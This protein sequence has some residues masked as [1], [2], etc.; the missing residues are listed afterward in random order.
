MHHCAYSKLKERGGDFRY[1]A[2]LVDGVTES[3]DSMPSIKSWEEIVRCQPD[4]LK[5]LLEKNSFQ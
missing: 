4:S 3:I 1:T 2:A 5:T